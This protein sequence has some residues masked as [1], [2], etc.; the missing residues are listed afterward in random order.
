MIFAVILRWNGAE[1]LFYLLEQTISIIIDMSATT[2]EELRS[3]RQFLEGVSSSMG[4]VESTATAPHGSL[5]EIVDENRL[6]DN[7]GEQL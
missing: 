6:R 7:I 5:S 2:T 4:G 1:F 3:I